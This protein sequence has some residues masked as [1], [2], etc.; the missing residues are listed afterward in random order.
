M[1][2]VAQR[3]GVSVTLAHLL[4]RFGATAAAGTLVKRADKV[5]Q[6]IE[7]RQGVYHDLL[8]DALSLQKLKLADD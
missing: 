6:A 2:S 8:V 7:K 5:M 4:Y 1:F 3:G